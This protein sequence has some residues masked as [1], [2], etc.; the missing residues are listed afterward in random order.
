MRMRFSGVLAVTL[1]TAGMLWCCSESPSE[2]ST[3]EDDFSSNSSSDDTG[4]EHPGDGTSSGEMSTPHSSGISTGTSS[5]DA[6]TSSSGSHRGRSSGNVAGSSGNGSTPAQ[7][8]SSATEFT[9]VAP[10]NFADTVNGAVFNM[11][12][13]PGGSYTRG[14]DNCAEQDKIYETPSHKVTVSDFH[15]ANTEVTI[16]QWNAVMGGKKNA[17]ESDKAPKSAGSTR[18]ISPASLGK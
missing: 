16:A 8:S 5:P 9:Y 3:T 4:N 18:T 14:C 17:W 12:Y 13:V 7:S 10:A 6:G 2:I 11:V 15:A 1:A